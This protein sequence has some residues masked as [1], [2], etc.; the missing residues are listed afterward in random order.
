MIN[1]F[2][3][4]EPDMQKPHQVKPLKLRNPYNQ[5]DAAKCPICGGSRGPTKNHR[6]CSRIL[7]Q[8]YKDKK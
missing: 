2:G 6:K 5:S 3:T 8:M 1:R 4:G 7:Q